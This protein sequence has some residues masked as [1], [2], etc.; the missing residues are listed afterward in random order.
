MKKGAPDRKL[1]IVTFNHE[2][3]VI[4]DGSKEP[5]VIA[6]DKL[7]NYDYLLENGSKVSETHLQKPI[8]ETSSK[9]AERVMSLEET[10]PTALG[11]AL[12]TAIAL[13]SNG[14]PG[15]AVI[16]CTDG[17]SNVGLGAFDEARTSD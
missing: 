11:P 15:S 9:L 3:T 16:L 12:A 17:L 1:G 2:V 5:Q 6:G 7:Y 10:G 13:A 4:G 14:A 8:K